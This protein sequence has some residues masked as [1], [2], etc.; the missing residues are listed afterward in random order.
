M[1]VSSSCNGKPIY[2]MGRYYLYNTGSSWWI[3]NEGFKNNCQSIGYFY[4]TGT[5]DWP[6]D[7]GCV[8][9]ANTGTDGGDSTDE[10][11]GR[12]CEQCGAWWE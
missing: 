6:T 12:W 10:C 3:S 5:C 7:D 4:S 11:L 2:N 8:W 1:P 9:W